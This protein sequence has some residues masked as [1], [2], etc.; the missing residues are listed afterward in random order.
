[1]NPD[2]AEVKRY[3]RAGPYPTCDHRIAG[4]FC[5]TWARCGRCGKQLSGER[6][7]GAPSEITRAVASAYCDAT[8]FK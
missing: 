5:W 7:G 1:M 3:N 6:V 2:V 4:L 8:G